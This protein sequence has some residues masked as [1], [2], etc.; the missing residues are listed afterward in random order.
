MNMKKYLCDIVKYGALSKVVKRFAILFALLSALDAINYPTEIIKNKSLLFFLSIFIGIIVVLL[1]FSYEN[2]I[3]HLVKAKVVNEL[4]SCF[5]IG[6][7]GCLC[8]TLLLFV[9]G[10]FKVYKLVICLLLALIALTLLWYRKSYLYKKVEEKSNE[11]IY[12]L[13]EFLE[14]KTKPNNN[15]PILFAEKDVAYDLFDRKVVINQLFSSLMACRFSDCSFV[16]G[17]EGPWGSG[18]TTIVNNVIKRINEEAADDFVLISNFDPWIYDSQQA[19][20][21]A[22][23]EKILNGSGIRYSA[24]TINTITK[25]IIHGIMGDKV[26]GIVENLLFHENPDDEIQKL[27]EQISSYLSKNNKTI[28]VFIDN[29]DRASAENL[30]FLLKIISTIFDLKRVVYVLSY[31]KERLNDILVNNFSINKHYI[32][33]IVQQEIKV[34]KLNRD[35]FRSI[36]SDCLYQ[37]FELYGVPKEKQVGFDYIIDFLSKYSEDLREFKRIINSVGTYLTADNKLYK[38]DLFCLELVRFLDNE[39]YEEIHNNAQYYISVDVDKNID[40]YSATFNREKFNTNGKEYFDKVANKYDP[41]LLKLLSNVFPYVQKYLNGTALRPEYSNDESKNKQISL[42]CGA[43]SAKYFDL[44]FHFGDNEYTVIS[45][46][47]RKLKRLI[48]SEKENGTLE[49]IPIVFDAMFDEIPVYYHLEIISKLWFERNDFDAELNLPIFV[50]LV[51]NANRIDK[52]AGFFTLSAYQRAG[53]IMATLFSL[54]TAEEK[55]E[56]VKYLSDS[57]KLLNT[58]D[59]IL[60]WLKASSLQYQQKDEDVEMFQNMIDNLYD[61]VME[62]S[63]DIYADNNYGYRNT[64]SL[65]RSKKRKLNL[66]EKE[67]VD[68]HEYV[69]KI[70]KPEY[71]FKILIDSTGMTTGSDGYGYY[72]DQGSL[73]ALFED[74]NIIDSYLNEVTPQNENERF[75]CTLYDAYKNGEVDDWGKK[76]VHV[77]H[78]IRLW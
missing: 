41:V 3:Q 35:K 31:D 14:N 25:N 62:N 42:N 38:P 7:V 13:K 26:G 77:D 23:F 11:N 12:D 49:N 30:I 5:T 71:V 75:I 34:T 60:Y 15:Y 57:Y 59:E 73:Q 70:M 47:Y 44:Y 66:G 6:F 55:M 76:S 1:L 39:L 32:E 74:E 78:Y 8:Y 17:L 10:M 50:G 63:I 67:N 22:L 61:N 43:A 53:S 4:D 33:K 40:L 51:E 48:F 20:L 2:N 37:L 64:W 54:L 46:I 68:I 72:I 9:P 58:F 16:I 18:K 52:E 27:K 21:V 29:L 65:L 36:V 19:L 56:L 69:S 45:S 24:S 28:T